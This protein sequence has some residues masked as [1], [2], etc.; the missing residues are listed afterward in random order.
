MELWFDFDTGLE[1]W[2]SAA[3]HV[4]NAWGIRAA[5]SHASQLSAPPNLFGF[6]EGK[7]CRKC[8]VAGR[9]I[10]AEF[11]IIRGLYQGHK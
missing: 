2:K 9:K 7:R 5:C 4:E 8:S 3:N 11:E 6:F 1:R 10:E